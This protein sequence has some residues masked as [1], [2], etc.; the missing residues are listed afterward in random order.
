MEALEPDAR[1]RSVSV[2][3]SAAMVVALCAVL[4]PATA[5]AK[6]FQVV[7]RFPVEL[8]APPPG[9][10]APGFER[11]V[12]ANGR[13]IGLTTD[14][15]TVFEAPVGATV[16]DVRALVPDVAPYS[17]PGH[18]TLDKFREV[19]L[20]YPP[21]KVPP[22]VGELVLGKPVIGRSET[23][24][25]A[26]VKVG[27]PI[28]AA[29][30]Q[31][32]A[33][34]PDVVFVEPNYRYRLTALPPPNDPDYVK[35]NLW[36]LTNIHAATAWGAV[37]DTTAIVAILDT[38]IDYTHPDLV[39]NVLVNAAETPDNT[40]DDDNDGCIDDV[41]GCDFVNGGGDVM[42]TSGHGTWVAG[43][44]GAVG[45]NGQG[46]VGV[47]WHVPLL[48]VRILASDGSADETTV[49]NAIEYALKRQARVLNASWSA[50][51]AE[52]VVVSDAI[53]DADTAG[54][55]L[56]ASSGNTPNDIDTTPVYPASYAHDNIIAVAATAYDTTT[57]IET[58]SG[59]SGFGKSVHLA[60]PGIEIE[61]TLLTH[62]YEQKS[63]T[64]FAVPFVSGAVALVWGDPRYAS[65]SAQEVRQLILNNVE[66]FGSFTGLCATSGRL[67]LKFLAPGD[68]Q[69]VAPGGQQ[70]PIP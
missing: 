67:D 19:V 29:L 37:H 62:G 11:T 1:R 9:K 60:A 51:G 40:K 61:T 3:A 6:V 35:D 23:G 53:S 13:Y 27:N 36:G 16:A 30:I 44:I 57:G 38:G 66:V 12:R 56:V 41:F 24:R 28:P 25:F 46:M 14:G 4:F 69:Q 18:G 43:I 26:V 2:Y 50:A 48:A 63:G 22:R 8:P 7:A 15:R 68:Q 45:N 54:A 49:S 17:G 21:N 55:L 33:D 39:C 20:L 31:Q 42:D 65:K 59:S 64:S 5:M 32:L 34:L 70:P 52:S 10:L 58:F 47:A